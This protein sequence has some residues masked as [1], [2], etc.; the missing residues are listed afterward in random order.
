MTRQKKRKLNKKKK[1]LSNQPHAKSVH[2]YEISPEALKINITSESNPTFNEKYTQDI[3]NIPSE[4]VENISPE[5]SSKKKK[6]K[7]KKNTQININKSIDPRAPAIDAQT[8]DTIQQNSNIHVKLDAQN[9][10][11][12]STE[13]KPDSRKTT[14][15]TLF[16]NVLSALFVIGCI[17]LVE[18]ISPEESI[19]KK[20]KKKK[21]NTQI[22]INKSI[23]P[24]APAIDAQTSDTIQQN[25]NI[26]VKLDAQNTKN[27]ST[28]NKPDSRKTTPRTLFY[29]VLSA[30]FVIAC[31]VLMLYGCSLIPSI[32]DGLYYAYK[33]VLSKAVFDFVQKYTCKIFENIIFK[34]ICSFVHEKIYLLGLLGSMII[35]NISNWIFL[36]QTPDVQSGS[37]FSNNT[38]SE[39]FVQSSQEIIIKAD[40]T[41]ACEEEIEEK[42]TITI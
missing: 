41:K 30:L 40:I 8:S 31:I 19:K 13:N 16:Y 4:I 3:N 37:E 28:E 35:K 27:T 34:S 42:V 9:T 18:N 11:N 17:V 21:K 2:V 25:S 33:V 29:N 5:K 22:N 6:K 36:P 38:P 32:P 26:H 7:K 12:T 10:K 1:Q 39:S 23:D 14:P 24:R 20:K 15:R